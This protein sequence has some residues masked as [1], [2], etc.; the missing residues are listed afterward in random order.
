MQYLIQYFSRLFIISCPL[1]IVALFASMTATSPLAE[2]VRPAKVGVLL[3][4]GTIFFSRWWVESFLSF[5][6]LRWDPF[7]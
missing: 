1:A 5:L 3:A 7:T 4:Y 2:R 6:E